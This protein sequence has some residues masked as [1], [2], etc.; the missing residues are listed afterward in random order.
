MELLRD[1]V[2]LIGGP[3]VVDAMVEGDTGYGDTRSSG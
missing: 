3:V 1:A 2:V